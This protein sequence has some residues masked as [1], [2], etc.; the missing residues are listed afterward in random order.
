MSA[1]PSGCNGVVGPNRCSLFIPSRQDAH[2][3]A[4]L[5]S[6]I[7]VKVELKAPLKIQHEAYFLSFSLHAGTNIFQCFMRSGIAR[8]KHKQ[9]K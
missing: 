2:L 3:K 7:T 6:L 5:E 1:L 8:N 9:V 4:F